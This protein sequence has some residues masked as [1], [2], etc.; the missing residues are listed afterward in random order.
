MR[1]AMPDDDQVLAT[2]DA[3]ENTGDDLGNAIAAD[4]PDAVQAHPSLV[5]PPAL[6]RTTYNYHVSPSGSDSNPGTSTA[7]FKTL[8][9]AARAATRPGTTVWVA[10]GRYTG[11]FKTTAHGTATARIHWV[12]TGQRAAVIVPDPL[13][14][15][16]A[17]W[18]NR[19]HHVSI[20]GFQVDG[21]GG[22]HWRFGLYSGGSYTRY[23]GNHVHHV[24]N[25]V[26]CDGTGGAGI[27]VDSYYQGV[28]GDVVGNVVHDIG[29]NPF[30][31][32]PCVRIQGIYMAT[33]G[34]VVNNVVYRASYGAIHLWHDAS[35]VKIINNTAAS[36]GYG[37]IVGGGDFR[38]PPYVA[39]NVHVHNNIV[40]DNTY[41]I[42]EIGAVGRN[43]TYRNNL[44]YLNR[45]SNWRLQSGKTHTGT[46]TADPLLVSYSRTASPPDL[47]LTPASPAI[48]RALSTYAPATDHD[49]KPR[50]GSAGYDIGAY[51]H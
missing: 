35:N 43:T 25:D 3:W 37:V 47:H 28:L 29:D 40:Y 49:G 1:P 13:S 48:G 20:Y 26:P 9:R 7:P 33:S 46:V 2:A 38:R 50:G 5:W 41:G 30:E 27:E 4:G 39:D 51:Q 36:S 32:N 34:S 10:P 15:A 44:V 12:S 45:L 19:G 18:D 6:P 17:A 31:P 16:Q 21:T 42:G 23:E 22:K 8:A 11:G 24:A 14:S